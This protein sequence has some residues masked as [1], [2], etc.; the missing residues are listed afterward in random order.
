MSFQLLNTEHLNNL[1]ISVSTY[2]HEPTGLLHYHLATAN[3]E[4]AFMIGFATQ[5]TTS[6]GEAH[7]LE[8]VVLCGSKQ[9]PV[10]D[11][12]FSMI[13]RSLQTFMNAMTASDWTAYPFATQNKKDYFNLL[14]VYLDAV[15]FPNIH[16][17]DFA[18]EGIRTEL[19]DNG[20]LSFHG[21]VFNEM[22][23]AM[24][25]EI[26]QLYYALAKHLFPTS[27]YQHNSGGNPEDIIK[28]THEDLVAFH[29]QYY[30]P[31]NAIAM[32]FGDIAVSEI[33]KQLSTV[34]APFAT[35]PPNKRFFVAKETRLSAPKY[36]HDTY[37]SA[38]DGAK[39][40][41]QVIAWLLPAITDPKLR[42]AMRLMEGV[43]LEHSG[44]PLRQY[45][46]TT[47][48][49]QA[50]SP[51][52][53]LDD[54]HFEMVFYA[55]VRGSDKSHSEAFLAEVLALLQDVAS[56]PIDP[57][58][59]A[60]VLH[61]MEL[62]ERHIGGD[63]MPYG[64]TLMFE[65]LATA[66]HGGEPI[67]VW[68]ADTHW[69]WLKTQLTDELWLPTLIQ[70]HLVDNPHRIH[71]TLSPDSTKAARQV[72]KEA[73]TLQ[74][75]TADLTDETRAAI[76]ANSAQLA[77]RQATID[78]VELLPKVTLADVP[79]AI[80][81]RE[82][83]LSAITING[84]TAPL[85]QYST[86]TNG[87]YYYQLLLTLEPD[88]LTNPLLPL[89]SY[90][91][92]EV[93]TDKLS[94]REFQA[95]QARHS[96][97]VGVRLSQRTSTDDPTTLNS[98]LVLATRAL[99]NKT[100]AMHVLQEV[101][102]DSVFSETARLKELLTQ[103]QMSWQ[104]R[105]S[106]AGHAYAMQTA[107]GAFNPY[108][109]LDY[110]YGG[111]PALVALK[112]FLADNDF[113]KLSY[114]LQ[115]LHAQIVKAPKSAILVCEQERTDAL[116]TSLQDSLASIAT[117]I[118]RAATLPPAF[119]DLQH[120]YQA[121]TPPSDTAWLIASNV[122]HNAQAYKTVPAGHPDAPALMVLA[123]VLRNGYLHSAIREQG[124]AYGGGA[125]YDSNTASLRFYS[126][127]DPHCAD[128]FK[129]FEQSIHWLLDNAHDNRTLEEAILGIIASMDKPASP[130]GE[131]IK[132]CMSTLHGRDKAWQETL[133]QAILAVTLDDLKRVART[134]LYNK[135]AT[136]ACIAPLS[137]KDTL[138][139]LGFDIHELT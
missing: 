123:V 13:K 10:R 79:Q 28:L 101:L 60:T 19:D 34:L 30:H 105:L 115:A 3:S 110:H 117:P 22:K 39:Q 21:I 111:L 96:A 98:F 68:Q 67:D 58:T 32:S 65:G 66:I 116:Q 47:P 64:L 108:G 75:L 5:P 133:R 129:H 100:E 131:A 139:Q 6:R 71:L 59:I 124:G 88:I 135:S 76:R 80:N 118:T 57:E 52:L 40:T 31:S 48:L 43:L 51:L 25:G 12:F 56:Q 78:D 112:T 97:G 119:A 54:N 93:G 49:G 36:V 83:R 107:T 24:S 130:A 23:G 81:F 84:Q 4:N 18:Q 1:A 61:Q 73:E 35:M 121:N 103:K 42:L 70:T 29:R 2:R 50:P 92:S 122:Y 41:H 136:R 38:D 11:P 99:A 16:P 102:S 95:R 17:L 120:A 63:G 14:S 62:E 86:G 106:N 126:Y 128:T 113:A 125:S 127:R 9:Y 55:G 77:A 72:A 69:Q 134:Y 27:T 46:E 91:L 26:E 87:L 53:G 85:Y 74:K 7:I 8:H 104:A 132:A 109:R 89:Y 114:A 94:A 20:Q 82:A 137:A 90:L 44:L 15:F 45:L 138:T 33:H 37:T